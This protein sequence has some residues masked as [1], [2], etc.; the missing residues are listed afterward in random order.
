M[1]V[2]VWESIDQCTNREHSEGGI[3]VFAGTE[4]RARK[5][6]NRRRMTKIELDEEPDAIRECADGPEQVFYMPDAGC[7]QA[8]GGK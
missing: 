3:V 7:C 4:D 5:L 1:K 6:A 8:E 2:F